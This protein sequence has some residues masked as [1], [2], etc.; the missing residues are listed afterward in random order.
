MIEFLQLHEVFPW[1]Q[2]KVEAELKEH[3]A[4]LAQKTLEH[5]ELKTHLITLRSFVM[6]GQSSERRIEYIT[7]RIENSLPNRI[8]LFQRRVSAF[9]IFCDILELKDKVSH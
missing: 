8:S 1:Q 4:F 7:S 2:D 5:E 3:E 6:K 9:N